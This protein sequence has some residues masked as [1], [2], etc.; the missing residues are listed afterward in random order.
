M[1]KS[2]IRVEIRDLP[3]N[4]SYEERDRAFKNML[5]AFKRQVNESGIL[6][7]YKQRQFYESPSEK[8]KRKKKE[9]ELELQKEKIRGRFS[10]KKDSR[11]A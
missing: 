8:R 3:P 5:S 7:E 9:A 6:S 2:L 11:N 10:N 1:R 4:P